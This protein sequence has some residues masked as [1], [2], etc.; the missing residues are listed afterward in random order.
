MRPTP[1]L[2]VAIAFTAVLALCSS[3]AKR[4]PIYSPRLGDTGDHRAAQKPSDCLACHAASD[5]S[6]SHSAQDPCLKCHK[7]AD[8]AAR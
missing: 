5:L 4:V 3:C 7:I 6:P 8:G 1:R 2:A